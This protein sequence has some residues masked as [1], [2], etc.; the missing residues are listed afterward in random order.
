MRWEL[1]RCAQPAGFRPISLLARP[2][3]CARPAS[4]A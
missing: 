2:A 1:R 4:A 3:R